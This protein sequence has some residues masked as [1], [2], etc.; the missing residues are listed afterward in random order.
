MYSIHLVV[1]NSGGGEEHGICSPKQCACLLLKLLTFSYLE[2]LFQR[3]FNHV[4]D[5]ET[6]I[7]SAT[8]WSLLWPHPTVD[9]IWNWHI[10]FFWFVDMYYWE[11][12][13]TYMLVFCIQRLFVTFLCWISRFTLAWVGFNNSQ[14][15]TRSTWMKIGGQVL[16]LWWA[17]GSYIYFL[18]NF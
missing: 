11:V 9:S 4:C 6:Q 1:K 18:A 15:C 12:L 10:P 7:H 5:E 8:H 13:P 14:L 3:I 16:A 17:L 2:F